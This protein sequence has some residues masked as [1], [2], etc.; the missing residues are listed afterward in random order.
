MSGVSLIGL[1]AARNRVRDAMGD[2]AAQDFL[3]HP[4]QRRPH[5]ADLRHDV[6]AIALVLDHAGE[7]THL[8]FDAAEPLER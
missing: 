3:F 5:R 7:A 4:A 8:A 2:V 6:D 1:V